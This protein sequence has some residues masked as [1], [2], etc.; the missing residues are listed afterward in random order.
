MDNSGEAVKVAEE[1]DELADVSSTPDGNV[2]EVR[3]EGS[4]SEE[5]VEGEEGLEEEEEEVEEIL[6]EKELIDRLARVAELKT[7]GNE[8]FGSGDFKRAITLYSEG[9]DVCPKSVPERA[10][11]F[12]NRAACYLKLDKFEDCVLDCGD[13]LEVTSVYPKVNLR[14]AIACEKLERY[15]EAIEDCKIVLQHE[16]HNQLANDAMKRL[17]ALLDTQR[18]KMKDEMLGN[19]KK[20]G[21]MCLRPFGLSTNN[22][23]MVQDPNTGGYSVNFNQ[24]PNQS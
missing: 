8:F 21:N 23:Q 9:L 6:T 4:S 2:E 18:E 14:R 17:P 3:E 15:D 19:L 12:A 1:P 13:A 16:P 5:E 20:L 22:F 24:N 11:L 10:P 7:Q